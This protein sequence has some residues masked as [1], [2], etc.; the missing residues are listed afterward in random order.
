MKKGRT[1][2]KGRLRKART[3]RRKVKGK[4]K[5]MM[6]KRRMRKM[7][8]LLKTGTVKKVTQLQAQEP[9]A[10][11]GQGEVEVLEEEVVAEE[12]EGVEA[13][14]GAIVKCL[15]MGRREG[16]SGERARQGEAELQEVEERRLKP[17]QSQVLLGREWVGG[18]GGTQKRKRWKRLQLLLP[19]R[20]RR[21]FLV[22]VLVTASHIQEWETCRLIWET[23]QHISVSGPALCKGIF[24]LELKLRRC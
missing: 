6:K 19:P 17:R 7:K 15:R 12:G 8:M 1:A 10:Q 2:M 9:G 16:R 4:G 23:A 5:K 22:G 11:V 18:R 13:E 20:H 21:S 24:P 14:L 3:M